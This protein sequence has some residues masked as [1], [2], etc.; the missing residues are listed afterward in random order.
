MKK[1]RFLLKKSNLSVPSGTLLTILILMD[2]IKMIM[3]QMIMFSKILVKYT[4][5]LVITWQKLV[6]I[7]QSLFQKWQRFDMFFFDTQT[8]TKSPK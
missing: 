6:G 7:F 2:G 8:D 3:S 5:S 1:S 4:N